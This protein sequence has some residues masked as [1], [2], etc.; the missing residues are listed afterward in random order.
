MQI[1]KK[2]FKKMSKLIKYKI[3]TIS[4]NDIKIQRIPGEKGRKLEDN[5]E[6]NIGNIWYKELSLEGKKIKIMNRIITGHDYTKKIL[7]D[8][9]IGENDQCEICNK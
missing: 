5:I 1:Y 2:K 3:E 9:E 8:I 7:E 4:A 6:K